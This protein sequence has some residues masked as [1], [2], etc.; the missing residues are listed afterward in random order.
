MATQT[1]AYIE[2]AGRGRLVDDWP[3]MF[4]PPTS[5]SVGLTGYL[6]PVKY[7][8]NGKDEFGCKPLNVESVNRLLKIRYNVPTPWIAVVQRGECQFSEKVWA[9]QESG[10]SAVIV[11]DDVV[12][13][14]IKMSGGNKS[15]KVNIPSTFISHWDYMRLCDLAIDDD[16][17]LR[18]VVVR[19]VSEQISLIP[20]VI[21]F[22]MMLVFV[23]AG[24][25]RARLDSSTPFPHFAHFLHDD[26]APARIVRDLPVKTFDHTK[27]AENDPDI[28]AICL[29]DFEDGVQLRKLP[30]KHE[31]HVNCVDPWLL[32][33]KKLCPICKADICPNITVPLA[34]ILQNDYNQRLSSFYDSDREPLLYNPLLL[35][36]HSGTLGRMASPLPSTPLSV[37]SSS[38]STIINLRRTPVSLSDTNLNH[39]FNVAVADQ[40]DYEEARLLA[41]SNNTPRPNQQQ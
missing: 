2:V 6:I 1:K 27:L 28:C 5:P 14:L 3:A 18:R 10:A 37:A 8:T 9:M 19:M 34:Y 7:L 26:P 16:G 36:P 31:F 13:P 12:G 20:I 41:Q 33:R 11:G 38:N 21:L 29:D 32:T 39:L 4:G 23:L 35:S 17:Q 30:C 25:W 24:L 22:V 15:D 40:S